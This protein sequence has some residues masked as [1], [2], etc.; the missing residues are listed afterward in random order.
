MG[1]KETELIRSAVKHLE[2]QLISKTE[3]ANR[4]PEHIHKGL[5]KKEIIISVALRFYAYGLATVIII[6]ALHP[7]DIYSHVRLMIA[8]VNYHPLFTPAAPCDKVF[9]SGLLLPLILSSVATVLRTVFTAFYDE[10]EKRKI[11]CIATCLFQT[12][13]ATL[14]MVYSWVPIAVLIYE[15][16]FRS[17]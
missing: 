8:F 6:F 5:M 4:E 14:F 1:P 2:L 7:E 12:I 13:A 16:Q 11:L 9:F 3:Q 15:T 10:G 17:L